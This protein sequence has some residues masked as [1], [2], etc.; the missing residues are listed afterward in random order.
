MQGGVFFISPGLP[1]DSRVQMPLPPPHALLI[2]PS[3]GSIQTFVTI[4]IYLYYVNCVILCKFGFNGNILDMTT[5]ST[6]GCWWWTGSWAVS[7]SVDTASHCQQ[8]FGFGDID[9]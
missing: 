1:G 5:T 3:L 7:H 8:D 4:Y 9:S 2:S 6:T